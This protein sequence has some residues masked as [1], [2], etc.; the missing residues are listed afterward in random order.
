MKFI[1]IL[2]V[3]L[4]LNPQSNNKKTFTSVNLTNEFN[5]PY[6]NTLIKFSGK[7]T[8]ISTFTDSL[9]N[10]TID[11]IKGDT[12]LISCIISDK[13][14]QFDNIIYIDENQNISSATINLQIDLY[15]SI[16]ELKNLN[17]ES[18]KYNISQKYYTDLNEIFSFLNSQK[19]INI[20][21]AG[22]TDNIGNKI[23]NQKLSNN[24]AN[25]VKS[26]LVQKG[27]DSNRIKCV[28]Y[29]EQQPVADNSTDSGRKKNRRIE[30]RILK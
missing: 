8:N 12:I 9:G 1:T 7:R 27:I 26:F 23:Y 3:F 13:E 16:I 29:G 2:L 20:E 4:H 18:A 21:I 25:S 15:E 30:I 5:V 24:R 14:Y 22:H 10:V 28:G 17:F 6:P 11:L 19:D